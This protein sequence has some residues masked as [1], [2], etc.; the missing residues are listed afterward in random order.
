MGIKKIILCVAA[1]ALA[2]FALA[3]CGSGGSSTGGSTG[4]TSAEGGGTDG[5]IGDSGNQGGTLTGAY[6]AFPDYLDPALS[7][8]GEGWTA[9]YSTYIPLLTYAH[10][11]GAAGG[12]VIPGLAEAMPK[13]TDN[14]KTYALK[15]L[16]GLKYSNGEPVRASDFLHSLERVYI[17][18]SSGSPFYDDIVGAEKFAKTKKGGISGIETDDK[19]GTITIHLTRPRGTFENELALPF[20]APLPANTPDE[21]LSADPPPATGPYMITHSKPGSGWEYERNPQWAQVNG[22]LM[23]QI[24][25][26]HVDKID[27]KVQ[28]N[29]QT[30]VNEVISGSLDWMANQVP[31][32]RYQEILTK[33][34][35]TQFRVEPTVSTYFFWMNTTVAPFDNLKVRQAV[36]YAI[37]PAALERIYSGR[38]KGNQQILPPEMPGGEKVDLYPHDLKKAKELIAEADPSDREITVWTETEPPSNDV[39][40]YYQGVL[41][42]LGFKV[43]LKIL[44]PDNYFTVIG[45]SSTPDLDTGWANWFQDYPHPNDFFQPLL[46]EES[47]AATNGTNLSRFADP[48]L[49]QKITELGEEPLGPEQEAAYAQLDKEFMEQAPMAPYGSSTAS[50]FVSDEINLEN[51]IYNPTFGQDLTSFEFK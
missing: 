29:P 31:P 14:G 49:S 13:V 27:I 5:A 16:K 46:S 37:N 47:I 23:P 43:S 33:Y 39:G 26:G 24:P 51:V 30:A 25:A 35:G 40:A 38:L 21:D 50:T 6:A 41:Q 7:H 1:C 4:G 17:L 44:S 3:A 19:T 12:K 2:A 36:N 8:T 10:A 15:L 22:K 34:E 18:N 32:D 42:E 9:M 11:N 48:K 20:A 28:R 45:N